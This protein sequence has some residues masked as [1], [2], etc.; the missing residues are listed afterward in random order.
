ME[1]KELIE[2][3]NENVRYL[4]RNIPPD[5]IYVFAEQTYM[6][7]LFFL[8]QWSE[9]ESLN[10]R[11]KADPVAAKWVGNIMGLLE[12]RNMKIDVDFDLGLDDL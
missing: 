8:Y 9:H 7:A 10:D 4:E 3:F 11:M 5:D 6:A 2:K 12:A 1:K